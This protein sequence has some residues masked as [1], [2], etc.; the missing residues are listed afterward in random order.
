[1]IETWIAALATLV[2]AIVALWR[3]LRR[4]TLRLDAREIPN[5]E[6]LRIDV[7]NLGRRTE[8]VDEISF[9]IE[10]AYEIISLCIGSRC[11]EPK[12]R[13]KRASQ[14]S[15]TPVEGWSPENPSTHPSVLVDESI[16][17]C[18]LKSHWDRNVIS[19][20]PRELSDSSSIY[21]H[22]WVKTASGY[23]ARANPD[24]ARS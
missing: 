6:Q 12:W 17:F 11:W 24:I 2:S 13:I 21:V 16:R 8:I 19:L 5:Q 9:G 3:V 1:M 20:I 18:I 10:I 22:V 23:R 15:S 14:R 7:D 4:P